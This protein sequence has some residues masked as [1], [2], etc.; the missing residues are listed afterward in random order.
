MVV[1]ALLGTCA[2]FFTVHA[3]ASGALNSRLTTS[4]G[5]GNA[6]YVL[7]Y[8]V[9]GAIG[10]TTSGYAW[11]IGGWPAVLAINVAM[12]MV[13]FGTGLYEIRQGRRTA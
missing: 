6:L 3:A 7:F 10:I 5:R 4:R 13:P 2:G 9:G 11:R 12:L 8:Y 1:L